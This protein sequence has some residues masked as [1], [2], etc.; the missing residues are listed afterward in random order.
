EALTAPQVRAKRL[1]LHY[2]R[3]KEGPIARADREKVQQILLNLV[4]NAV[5]F[6]EPGG[7]ITFECAESENGMVATR[8]TDTGRGMAV[9]QLERIFQPFVQLDATLTRAHQ[10]TGLGLAISRDLARGMRGDLMV[11]KTSPAGSTF[12]L[13]LPRA[14][15]AG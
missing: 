1:A 10:G 9:D 13:T 7:S 5:K 15:R 12:L 6:T 3:C 2:E 4:S 8:V 14:S 11:E